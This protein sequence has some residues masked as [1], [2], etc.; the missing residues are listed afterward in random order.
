LRAV[1]VLETTPKSVEVTFAGHGSIQNLNNAAKSISPVVEAFSAH[2]NY[3][4]P[5]TI[6]TRLND[7]LTASVIYTFDY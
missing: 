3:F 7:D 1:S 6:V 2:V 5:S 4:R